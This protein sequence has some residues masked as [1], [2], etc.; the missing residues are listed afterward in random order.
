MKY[1]R[2]QQSFF[3]RDTHDVAKDMLGKLLVRNIEGATLLGRITEV[4][5]YVGEDDLACHASKGR[6]PRT[7]VLFQEPGL[8]YVYLIYG[9]YH[10]LNFVT[11]KKD[12]PAAVL[13]RAIEPIEGIEIMQ[14]TTKKP[15][16]IHKLTNGPGKVCRAMTI[17]R[18]LTNTNSV[19]SDELYI[20]D[21]GFDVSPQDI[22]ST[23]RI[24]VEYAGSCALYPWRYYITDSK[25]V[26]RR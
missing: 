18:S 14:Q 23:T 20:A 17:D 21:D 8:I 6:T 3:A 13:L 11:E 22:T 25:Y 19:K 10:C 24:G 12:F 4:E 7:E 15:T 5:S 2:L 16:V 26:S 1:K 9:M